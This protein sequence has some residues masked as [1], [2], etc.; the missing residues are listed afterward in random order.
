MLL[1]WWEVQSIEASAP[2]ARESPTLTAFA[3][4]AV[5]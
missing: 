2:W 1:G 3:V 5:T 4:T